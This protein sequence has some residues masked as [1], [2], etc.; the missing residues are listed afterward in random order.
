MVC[1][2][3]SFAAAD[4][5][6]VAKDDS[7]WWVRMTTTTTTWVIIQRTTTQ[8]VATTVATKTTMMILFYSVQRKDNYHKAPGNFKKLLR[9]LARPSSDHSITRVLT[10][11]IWNNQ[12]ILMKRYTI[13]YAVA[14]D[15]NVGVTI[16]MT[17]TWVIQR[18]ATQVIATT[19]VVSYS[20]E[21]KVD[22]HL[23]CAKGQEILKLLR[24]QDSQ[25]IIRSLLSLPLEWTI[26]KSLWK[27][28][29]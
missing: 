27:D 3:L 26:N 25:V 4:A 5:A 16:P 28:I 12:Q 6:V 17:T 10:S 7:N 22:F 21:E 8:V 20:I 15:G 9:L 19:V 2:S 29:Q 23:V 18:T 13:S 14:V 1:Y 24:L 11:R